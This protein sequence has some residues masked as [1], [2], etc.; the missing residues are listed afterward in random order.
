VKLKGKS[1]GMNTRFESLFN[2][3]GIENRYV[4]NDFEVLDKEY[5]FVMKY[6]SDLKYKLAE[7]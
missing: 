4:D 2:F 7:S 1:E 3:L 5:F 6:S